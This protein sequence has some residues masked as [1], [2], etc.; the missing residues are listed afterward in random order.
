MKE[1]FLGLNILAAWIALSLPLDILNFPFEDLRE[2]IVFTNFSFAST[3]F[4]A[5]SF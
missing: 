4:M 1:G 2:T 3:C 5:N